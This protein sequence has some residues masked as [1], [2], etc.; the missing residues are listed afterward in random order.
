VGC[1][2]SSI[3]Q[4]H[5]S[6]QLDWLCKTTIKQKFCISRKQKLSFLL[7]FRRRSL[8]HF[9]FHFHQKNSV[10]IFV[11]QISIFISIFSFRFRFSAEKLKSF[12]STFIARWRHVAER[13]CHS[14]ASLLTPKRA[15]FVSRL[16][17]VIMCVADW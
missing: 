6:D 11:S 12:R 17:P 15:S 14:Q 2:N 3:S 5:I 8:F 7:L 1:F 13:G 9:R 4:G 10:S 16:P